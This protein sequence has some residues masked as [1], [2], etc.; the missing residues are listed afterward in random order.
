MYLCYRVTG[1]YLRGEEVATSLFSFAILICSFAF[2]CISV[3]FCHMYL[4]NIRCI[5]EIKKCICVPAERE[6]ETGE[7]LRGDVATSLSS[8]TIFICFFAFCFLLYFFNL[9]KCI[10]EIKKKYLCSRWERERN[11]RV[12]E[13]KE[14]A[15]SLSSYKEQIQNCFIFLYFFFAFIWICIWS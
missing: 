13:R 12:F 1:E 5:C 7:Y 6:R 2:C 14:V 8:Y 4:W 9:L 15:T 3:N 11:W 10:C